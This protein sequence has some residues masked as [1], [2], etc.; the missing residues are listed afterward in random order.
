MA[1]VS[2]ETRLV[3]QLFR[4]KLKARKLFLN[5][6]KG[7]ELEKS[8]LVIQGIEYAEKTLAGIVTELERGYKL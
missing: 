2:N 6:L 8:G 5:S 1:K 7:P 3:M 4:E